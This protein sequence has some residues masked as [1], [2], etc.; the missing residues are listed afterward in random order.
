MVQEI[1]LIDED[2]ELKETLKRIFKNDKEYRFTSVAT[3][4]LEIAL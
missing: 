4:K 3:D 1:Y 2:K